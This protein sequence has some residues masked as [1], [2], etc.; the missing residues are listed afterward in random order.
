MKN[1]LVNIPTTQCPFV[2]QDWLRILKVFQSRGSNVWINAGIFVKQLPLIGD[3]ND[4]EWLDDQEKNLLQKNKVKTKAGFILHS[5]KRN[6]RAIKNYKNILEESHFDFIYAPSSVLDFVLFPFY[7]KITGKK[8][9]W[10]TN[11]A[12]LVPAADPGNKVIRFLAWIFFQTSVL[13]LRKADLVFTPTPEIRNYLLKRGFPKEKL[14]E[15]SFAVENDLIEKAR[16]SEE[17]ATDA[18]FVGRINETKGIFDMLKVL[19]IVKKKYSEFQLTILGEGDS[20]TTEKFKKQID[21]MDLRNNVIFL[22]Y[23]AGQKKYDIIKSAICFWFLSV[24][25]SES[26]GMALLEAVCSGVPAFAY[27]LPQFSR[28]Y[29]NGEVDISPKGDYQTVAEKVINLFEQG[30]FSNE[31]GKLLLGKYSWRKIAE[32][33]FKAMA[34]IR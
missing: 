10:A 30:N 19:Q 25:R 2:T 9:G 1:I 16:R 29:P 12:N 17:Y 8:I 22:G 3:V 14:I 26:F 15:T 7:L 24:S 13:M 11:L 18:L 23:I 5:L 27:N 4:F 32:T 28:L 34:K 33:E 20:I 31:K 6:Y 21:K